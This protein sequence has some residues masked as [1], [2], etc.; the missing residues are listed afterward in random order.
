MRDW[1]A[2]NA[3]SKRWAARD[4]DVIKEVDALFAS[5][6]LTKDAVMAQTLAVNIEDV[7]RIDRMIMSAETRC[8]VTLREIDRHCAVLREK[9]RRATENI[10]DA[11]FQIVVPEREKKEECSARQLEANPR[12]ARASTGPPRLPQAGYVRHR[13]R[14]ATA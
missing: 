3:L 8:N 5:A 10:E 12:N 14:A 1:S 7:E 2:A 11:D 13:M 9:L 6:D 4:P